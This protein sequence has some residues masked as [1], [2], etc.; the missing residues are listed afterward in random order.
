ML[1]S[2]YLV[3]CTFSEECSDIFLHEMFLDNT[4]CIKFVQ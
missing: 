3:E 4:K 2:I 1:Y